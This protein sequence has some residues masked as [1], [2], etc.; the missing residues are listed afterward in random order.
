MLRVNIYASGI[1]RRGI[2]ASS[3][4]IGSMRCDTIF[5][6]HDFLV[7]FV[8][9]FIPIFVAMDIPGL[10]PVFVSLTQGLSEDETR[11]VA[12]QALVTALAI[13]LAFLAIGKFIFRVLGIT[14]SDFQI[15]GGLLLLMVGMLE[16]FQSG[17]PRRVPNAHVGPVPLGTPLMVGPAVLTSLLILVPLRGYGPTLA[18]L[19]AN[20]LLVGAAFRGSRRVTGWVSEHGLRAVSQVIGLFLAAIAVSM[21]R[22]GFQ[23]P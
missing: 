7:H 23:T 17:A 4:H 6:M 3:I 9:S 2:K 19:A 21:I 14:A 5:L 20:L 13:S 10:I 18:A 16:I 1:G 11:G 15:S 22:R 8:Y 12:L